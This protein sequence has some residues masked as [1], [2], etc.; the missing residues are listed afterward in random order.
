MA[1]KTSLSGATAIITGAGRGIGRAIT[2]SLAEAGVDVVPV[3]RTRKELDD[4]A[5]A[6]QKLG[7]RVVPVVADVGEEAEVRAMVRTAAAEFERIDILV[8]NAG[9]G[10][11]SPVREM[12][13]A[14][15]DAMWRVNMRGL[16]L[17]T[18]EVLPMMENQR[19][20]DIVN[21][22]SLAGRNAFTGGA[23]YAATKWAVIGFSRC[24]MLEVRDKNIRV[25]TL[26]PGSVDTS[27][28]DRADRSVKSSGEIPAAHDIA[29]VV[30]NALSMPRNVMV[31]EIDIRPTNPK[32]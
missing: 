2:L 11:F 24:L 1:M 23:G 8:N 12:A 14:E 6:V 3:S 10:H 5:G 16:F 21:I 13:A 31:S 27:F 29:T 22:A 7:R 15:F 25:M 9:I 20:G 26:C 28:G 30:L 18:R 32:G 4:L 17:C 19:S